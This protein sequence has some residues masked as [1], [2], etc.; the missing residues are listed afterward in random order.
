MSGPYVARDSATVMPMLRCVKASLAAGDTRPGRDE[1]LDEMP[2][3]RGG[4]RRRL[5]LQPVAR[6]DFVDPDAGRH[7]DH[8][9]ECRRPDRVRRGR[10]APRFRDAADA[11]AAGGV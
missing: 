4:D 6:P 3:R 5:V 11:P 1:Q 7:L 9:P 10:M 2:L 8:A